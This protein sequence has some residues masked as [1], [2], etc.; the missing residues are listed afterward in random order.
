M[1]A[2][3]EDYRIIWRAAAQREPQAMRTLGMVA[4]ASCR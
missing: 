1:N 4:A 3:L 2:A